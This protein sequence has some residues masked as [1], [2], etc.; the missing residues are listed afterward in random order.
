[1]WQCPGPNKSVDSFRMSP[2]EGRSEPYNTVTVRSRR[3]TGQLRYRQRPP[4]IV[5]RGATYYR[6]TIPSDRHHWGVASA[7]VES[8]WVETCAK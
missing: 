3:E 2:T 5:D 6:T 4:G 7:S 8:T 1:M